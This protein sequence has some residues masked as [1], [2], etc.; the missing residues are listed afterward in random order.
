MDVAPIKERTEVY[1]PQPTGTVALTVPAAGV[2]LHMVGVHLYTWPAAGPTESESVNIV[3]DGVGALLA[4]F[5]VCQS[6]VL[7]AMP[8]VA[9]VPENAALL[10][11]T[12]G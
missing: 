11:S 9:D 7:L 3:D 6:V 5:K 10:G 1:A 8:I 2:P 12:N 4:L